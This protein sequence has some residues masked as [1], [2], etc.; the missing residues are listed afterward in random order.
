MRVRRLQPIQ[1]K[2]K[3][4]VRMRLCLPTPRKPVVGQVRC[5][6]KELFRNEWR[7]SLRLKM[8]HTEVMAAPTNHIT[9]STNQ[10][11][12][13]GPKREIPLRLMSKSA[14]APL[15]VLVAFLDA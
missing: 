2:A 4:A 8:R 12:S 10:P 7:T 13:S 11:R 3:M 14:F 6:A 1:E 5:V 9:Q 15:P